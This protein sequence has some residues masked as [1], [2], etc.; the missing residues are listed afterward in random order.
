MFPNGAD[1]VPN[2]KVFYKVG[3]FVSGFLLFSS[4]NKLYKSLIIVET[5]KFRFDN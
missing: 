4:T 5:N 1:A 2:E 3:Q